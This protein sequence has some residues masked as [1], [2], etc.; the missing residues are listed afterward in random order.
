[1]P[2]TFC[3]RPADGTAG[4]ARIY[5][6]I[7]H[8][9]W[10]VRIR[11]ATTAHAQVHGSSPEGAVSPQRTENLLD[12]TLN[13]KLPIIYSL[14]HSLTRLNANKKRKYMSN[15]DRWI[16]HTIYNTATSCE[17]CACQRAQ[18]H[19][20]ERDL[21]DGIIFTKPF[22][23]LRSVN[24]SGI[25]PSLWGS[26]IVGCWRHRYTVWLSYHQMTLLLY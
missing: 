10:N 4:F 9:G 16:Y 13:P 18:N 8:D 3:H 12:T 7:I 21:H 24:H 26:F 6:Q 14:V 2:G 17:I 23:V 22:I 20:L 5:G 15:S 11:R 1:M 19:V 25:N